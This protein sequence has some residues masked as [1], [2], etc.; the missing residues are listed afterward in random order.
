MKG[1][2]AYGTFNYLMDGQRWHIRDYMSYFSHGRWLAAYFCCPYST[3]IPMLLILRA[4]L[5]LLETYLIKPQHPF[6]IILFEPMNRS[7]AM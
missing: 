1:I 6:T 3:Q 5:S 7:A 4:L 2:R